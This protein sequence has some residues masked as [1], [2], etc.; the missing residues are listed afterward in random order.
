MGLEPAI[1]INWTELNWID[2]NN[3]KKNNQSSV[4]GPAFRVQKSSTSP[5]PC[6]CRARSCRAPSIGG[7]NADRRPSSE[8]S[9]CCPA[10]RWIRILVILCRR[11]DIVRVDQQSSSRPPAASL[12]DA[13]SDGKHRRQTV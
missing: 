11:L 13:L 9:I 6:R 7:I 10:S 1:E 12:C 3:N 2:N 8:I 4:L 5:L